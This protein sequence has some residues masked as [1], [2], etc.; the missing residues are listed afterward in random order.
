MSK[1]TELKAAAARLLYNSNRSTSDYDMLIDFI[2]SHFDNQQPADVTDTNDGEWMQSYTEIFR[3]KEKLEEAEIP[4]EFVA[5]NQMKG[6]QI[7][8]PSI[9]GM[10]CSVI[11]HRYSYGNEADLLEIMGILTSEEGDGG[12]CPVLG[13]QTAHSVFR[14]IKKHWEAVNK[15]D[16]GSN[17]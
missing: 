1:R 17:D 8:Y 4:F 6:Y 16:S 12:A 10:I 2:D 5:R 9:E 15:N 3:L 11:Q 7:V 14:R 13:W